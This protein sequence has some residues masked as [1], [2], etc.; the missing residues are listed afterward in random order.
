MQ[1]PIKKHGHQIWWH[2]KVTTTNIFQLPPHCRNAFVSNKQRN[3]YFWLPT[4]RALSG[5]NWNTQMLSFFSLEL[6]YGHETSI[7]KTCQQGIQWNEVKVLPTH[8]SWMSKLRYTTW[9]ITLQVSLILFT[10]DSPHKCFEI[11]NHLIAPSPFT[12][13]THWFAQSSALDLRRKFAQFIARVARFPIR[14]CKGSKMP[15]QNPRVLQNCKSHIFTESS[16]NQALRILIKDSK[17]KTGW[18]SL[19]ALFS[20]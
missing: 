8:L 2:E 11:N 14:S 5:G 19:A 3:M 1:E 18:G 10:K 6:P 7:A 17:N 13:V 9:K 15:Q 4:L 20:T 16:N 12:M